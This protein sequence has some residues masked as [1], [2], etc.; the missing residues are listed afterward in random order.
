[1][2]AETTNVSNKVQLTIVIRWV[3]DVFQIDE[4]WIGMSN[5]LSTTAYRIIISIK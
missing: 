5:L 4:D 1:M 3:D 2:V